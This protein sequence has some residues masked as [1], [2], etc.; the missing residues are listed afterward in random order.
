MSAGTQE[1]S[2]PP[3]SWGELPSNMQL[4]YAGPLDAAAQSFL[5]QL[6]EAS[7]CHLQF[8]TAPHAAAAL[9]LL[10]EKP[11]D[12]VLLRHAPPQ[13]DAL[14][15]LEAARAAIGDE[16][17]LLVLGDDRLG[18][19]APRCYEAGGDD[20]LPFPVMAADNCTAYL[21]RIS[22]AIERGK[23]LHAQRRLAQDQQQ[24][25][26][27][28]HREASDLLAQQRSLLAGLEQLA[29]PK[30]PAPSPGS[31]ATDYQDLLRTHV[32]MGSGNLHADLE[33]LCGLLV[34]AGLGPADA[35]SLHVESLEQMV[36]GLGSRSARHVMNRADLLILELMMHL[37]EC[38]RTQ[39]SVAA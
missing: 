4:L 35:M 14:P 22:R 3:A 16:L 15:L 31:L 12:A 28:E 7:S 1:R 21:W 25:L 9:D 13:V 37:A 24:R 36:R 30:T 32:I 23:L 2:T 8:A 18:R 29:P 38:Y 33:R 5:A 39:R 10:A 26:S 27:R 17:P 11:C 6:A 19:L 34:A 20:F